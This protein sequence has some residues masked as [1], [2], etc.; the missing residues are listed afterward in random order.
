MKLPGGSYA[1]A[2]TARDMLLQLLEQLIQ[3]QQLQLSTASSSKKAL[4][5]VQLLLQQEGWKT[6]ELARHLMWLC[7]H[8]VPKAIASSIIS[9]CTQL[10]IF[11]CFFIAFLIYLLLLLLLLSLSLSLYIY[12]YI[13]HTMSTTTT[14]TTITSITTRTTIIAIISSIVSFK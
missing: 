5:L 10:V 2:L 13:R 11:F 3:E 14:S 6:G 9:F 4:T 8:L 7:S 1:K 12:I